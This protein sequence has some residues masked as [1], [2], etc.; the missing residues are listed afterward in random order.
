MLIRP[1][2]LATLSVANLRALPDDTSE[3]V[4]Q[5]LMGTPMKILEQ[6]EKWFRVQTP[7]PYI[8]WMD[9]SGLQL[10]DEEGMAEWRNSSRYLYTR[11][12]G[13]AYEYPG[14]Q[15]DVVTDLTLGDLFV[16]D[17]LADDFL[18]MKTPDGREGYVGKDECI[19]FDEWSSM[20]PDIMTVIKVARQMMG[21]PYLWGGASG[22]GTDCSGFTRLAYFSQGIILARDSSQQAKYGE[23]VDIRDMA[24]LQKGDLLFFGRSADRVSHVGIYLGNG[25][26]IH[27]SGRVHISSIIPGD[28]KHV[29]AR[30][31]ISARRILGSEGK[32]GIVKVRSHGW[33]T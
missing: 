24:N 22:K 9:G 13:F 16:V 33:Y 6:K 8:G 32:E 1:W 20:E 4:S 29:P 11:L 18:R 31:F 30:I 10:L 5:A 23:P 19:S 7:E 17:R 12:S 26:F 2:A 3:L 15:V 28:P 14:G 21:S 25:N 27:S